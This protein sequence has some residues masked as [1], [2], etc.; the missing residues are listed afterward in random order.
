MT[1]WRQRMGEDKIIALLQESIAVAVRTGAMKPQDTRRVIVDTTVQPK[2]VMFPTDAKLVHRARER[3]VRLAKRVGLDLRQSY[4]RVG[5]KALIAHQ[6]YGPVA[7]LTKDATGSAFRDAQAVTHL[8]DTFT[9]AC[10]A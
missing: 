3:L 4:V 7:V 10:G 1:R 9:A 6:R 5:K 2:N 8:I